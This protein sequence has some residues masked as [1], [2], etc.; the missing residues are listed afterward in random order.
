MYETKDDLEDPGKERRPKNFLFRAPLA[1][2]STR[3]AKKSSKAG[4][5]GTPVGGAHQRRNKHWNW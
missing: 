5:A 4:K 3:R 2:R 1:A